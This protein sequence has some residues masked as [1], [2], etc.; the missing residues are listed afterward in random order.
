MLIII[1]MFRSRNAERTV[2][3]DRRASFGSR[4]L[5]RAGKRKHG[6]GYRMRGGRWKSD[7]VLALVTVSEQFQFG[8][9]GDVLGAVAVQRLL[10]GQRRQSELGEDPKSSQSSSQ[11][12]GGVHSNTRHSRQ[13]VQ[14]FDTPRCP[15]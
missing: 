5:V 7:A 4:E 14:Y 9:R 12:Y 11:R 2:S 13:P 10:P 6:F 15:M 3:T 8:K 1:Y